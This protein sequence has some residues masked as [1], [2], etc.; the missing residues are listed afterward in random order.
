MKEKILELITEAQ[1]IY[2]MTPEE[3]AQYAADEYEDFDINFALNHTDTMKAAILSAKIASI[4]IYV[5]VE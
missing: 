1:K 3:L 5:E 2:K 4:K